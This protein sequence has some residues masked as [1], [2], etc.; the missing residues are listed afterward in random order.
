MC[1][2]SCSPPTRFS[3][4]MLDTGFGQLRVTSACNN[5][6]AWILWD[7]GDGVSG[8]GCS[9]FVSGFRMVCLWHKAAYCALYPRCA[10]G[11]HNNIHT[12]DST[13]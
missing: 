11:L 8:V 6:G 1:W 12:L 9:V 13:A 3:G 7:A 10:Q 2:L 4:L 5:E